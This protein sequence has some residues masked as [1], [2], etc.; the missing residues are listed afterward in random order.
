MREWESYIECGPSDPPP[1]ECPR[2]KN[3]L[4]WEYVNDFH[5]GTCVFCRNLRFSA[6]ENKDYTGKLVGYRLY[7]EFL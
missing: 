3:W 5:R 2:C 4:L 7:L 1:A 6:A